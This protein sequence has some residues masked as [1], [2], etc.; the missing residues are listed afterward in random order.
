MLD[1]R[2]VA[3]DPKRQ[4]EGTGQEREAGAP[5]KEA[6][7]AMI[8][9]AVITV[10]CGVGLYTSL[11]MLDKYGR[12]ARGELREPSVVQSPRAHL[13]GIPNTLLGALYYPLLA[14]GI[15]LLPWPWAAVLL[16]A[17]LAAALMSAFLAYSLLFITRSSCPYCWASHVANWALLVL[18]IHL[19]A[20]DILS[21]GGRFW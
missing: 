4:E 8:V 20:A 5:P 1:V 17:A 7:Q 2:L 11:F 3:N 6:I 16:V 15:W 10:L 19:F 9:R 21:M 14:I 13:L 18:C 12:A